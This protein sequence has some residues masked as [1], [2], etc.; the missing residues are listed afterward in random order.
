MSDNRFK[1]STP[2]FHGLDVTSDGAEYDPRT[3]ED[4]MN[5]MLEAADEY[6]EE[7]ITI[8]LYAI[9]NGLYEQLW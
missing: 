5:D 9:D 2:F 7:V 4:C 8:A 3:V 1:L 6:D